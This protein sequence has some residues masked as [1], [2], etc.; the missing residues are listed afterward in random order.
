MSNHSF[1]IHIATEYKSVELAILIWHFHYWIMKNKRLNRNCID[2][3]TW[4]YQ[5]YEEIVASFPYWSRD[6]V[7][8]L[9]K[10]AIELKILIKNSYNS[11]KYDQTMWYAFEN[12][13]RFGISR[14]REMDENEQ[15]KKHATSIG[16][17]R[18]IDKA[19][20][21]DEKGQIALPI[22]DTL[23]YTLTNKE[24]EVAAPPSARSNSK[25][26]KEEVERTPNVRTTDQ[27]HSELLK[28]YG[29]EAVQE[30]YKKLSE[31]KQDTPKS[32]WKLNDYR[33]ILRWVV[34]ACI[35]KK[36]QC[37]Q[38]SDSEKNKELSKKLE[39]KLKY[40]DFDAGN[41]EATF[42]Y[43]GS[44]HGVTIKYDDKEF[45]TKFES[46]LRNKKIRIEDLEA[47]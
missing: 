31:W 39:M 15:D 38:K 26:K 24:R 43:P 42:R 25:N 23:P 7:K 32:K 28:K 46:Q 45:K 30:F 10:K 3:R 8:R 1:D 6:Q 40:H 20:S 35:E 2:G 34:D 9:L 4:T 11:N 36:A 27:E 16:R 14:F 41:T 13:E 29:N 21:P 44:A 17:N 19:K 5:T 37:N 33:S 18:P 47:M 12:E 22:P